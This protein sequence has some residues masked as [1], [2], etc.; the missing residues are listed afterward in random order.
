MLGGRSGLLL[1]ILP[2][3]MSIVR[4]ELY[5]GGMV[6]P[7]VHLY[8]HRGHT[9]AK[10]L[11]GLMKNTRDCLFEF[12]VT[13][14]DRS[15]I[16]YWSVSW[17]DLAQESSTCEDGKC[18]LFSR[19]STVHFSIDLGAPQPQLLARKRPDPSIT[20]VSYQPEGTIFISGSSFSADFINAITIDGSICTVDHLDESSITCRIDHHVSSVST[21]EISIVQTG[22]KTSL[23]YFLSPPDDCT[24][25]FCPTCPNPPSPFI[26]KILTNLV[27]YITNM[28]NVNPS[29]LR[30]YAVDLVNINKLVSSLDY[31]LNCGTLRT[32]VYNVGQIGI[33]SKCFSNQSDVD[34][35]LSNPNLILPANSSQLTDLVQAVGGRVPSFSPASIDRYIYTIV[36]DILRNTSENFSSTLTDSLD[37][38]TQRYVFTTAKS[39]LILQTASGGVQMSA[40]NISSS[41]VLSSLK[42]SALPND[43]VVMAVLTALLRNP[44]Q[45]ISQSATYSDVIGVTLY[46][47][48]TELRVSNTTQD[49]IITMSNVR[50]PPSGR[51]FIC[52][53]WKDT[54][55]SPNGCTYH[56]ENDL[57]QCYCSHLTSFVL[58]TKETSTNNTGLIVGVVVG[59]IAAI[60]V[61]GIVIFVVLRMKRRE[62]NEIS[63]D[64]VEIPKHIPH[65]QIEYGSV[66]YNGDHVIIKKGI[67]EN[68]SVVLKFHRKDDR[69][70]REISILRV[71][72]HPMVVQ[73]Y[74]SCIDG[75]GKEWIVLENVP[76]GHLQSWLKEMAGNLT[77]DQMFDLCLNISSVV[78]Y[79]HGSGIT[80]HNLSTTNILI[81]SHDPRAT[82][83]RLVDFSVAEMTSTTP[84]GELITVNSDATDKLRGRDDV[85]M[86]GVIMWEVQ[87]QKPFPQDI[88]EAKSVANGDLQWQSD[89]YT[90]LAL[91]CLNDSP[92]NRPPFPTITSRLNEEI[93]EKRSLRGK[94]TVLQRDGTSVRIESPVLHSKHHAVNEEEEKQMDLKKREETLRGNEEEEKICESNMRRTGEDERTDSFRRKEE[95]KRAES[96][97]RKKE[98]EER[99][100]SFRRKTEEK[101]SMR[102]EREEE[103]IEGESFIVLQ[104]QVKG[105]ETKET[106]AEKRLKRQERQKKKVSLPPLLPLVPLDGQSPSENTSTEATPRSHFNTPRSLN[107][108]P[109]GNTPRRS[110]RRSGRLDDDASHL[111]TEED[112]T[113]MTIDEMSEDERGNTPRRKVWR[114]QV[115][116]SSEEDVSEDG[117]GSSETEESSRVDMYKSTDR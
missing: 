48:E 23:T 8:R 87:H 67:Y 92:L 66:I 100:Q 27:D 19:D 26:P 73:Y 39:D 95:E 38:V 51:E 54:D 113:T 2:I 32:A 59:V 62:R 111:F 28:M 101:E 53:F 7:A 64:M 112:P 30:C 57:H 106:R 89:L 29:L 5:C 35:V 96:F 98:E 6:E 50:A 58:Q 61:I 20:S 25:N 44:Y 1:L 33:F 45:N 72:H 63:L 24:T 22:L 77:E 75:E 42:K 10:S 85:W 12:T 69:T 97:R 46:Y 4:A 104:T 40:V 76:M 93:K 74:G 102:E 82:V 86:F 94:T 31:T 80:L 71:L 109:R 114:Q 107:N 34:F 110:L 99:A 78:S 47:N 79:L 16:H 68:S 90:S 84:R 15:D 55:W 37:I 91:E 115:H 70:K 9:D 117:Q 105:E 43:T 108:T 83:V 103:D 21:V 116:A 14:L 65:D 88:L 56:R 49:I 81:K 3:W 11:M 60:V 41:V 18:S 13:G 17:K 52:M 36:S